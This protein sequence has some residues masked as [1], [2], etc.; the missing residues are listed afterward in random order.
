MSVQ[1]HDVHAHN[2]YSLRACVTNKVDR[3]HPLLMRSRMACTRGER[4]V[5]NI[6]LGWWL[7]NGLWPPCNWARPI[8]ILRAQCC[9]SRALRGAIYATSMLT[10]VEAGY[11]DVFSWDDM[12]FKKRP[13]G[14]WTRIYFGNRNAVLGVG[15]MKPLYWGRGC[16]CI[17]R[18]FSHNPETDIG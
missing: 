13:D 11:R 8:C 3:A 10:A 4:G 9:S 15:E 7:D 2:V 6:H 14:V 17:S 16:V 1:V 5:I 18:L 12:V